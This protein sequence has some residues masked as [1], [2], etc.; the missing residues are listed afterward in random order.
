MY[1]YLQHMS[2][3]LYRIDMIILIPDSCK[4]N[5]D[6]I[7]INGP[8]FMATYIIMVVQKLANLITIT[9]NETALA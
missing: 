7:I 1:T 5:I 2:Y 8:E 4:R 6:S 3:I 9:L